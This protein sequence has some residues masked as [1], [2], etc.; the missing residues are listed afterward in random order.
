MRFAVRLE[1][2]HDVARDPVQRRGSEF[3]FLQSRPVLL[4]R[5]QCCTAFLV[6]AGKCVCCAV[7]EQAPAVECGDP[8]AA[9]RLACGLARIGCVERVHDKICANSSASSAC[10][11]TALLR[12]LRGDPSLLREILANKLTTLVSRSELVNAATTD[13]KKH[14]GDQFTENLLHRRATLC[15]HHT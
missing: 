7:G 12:S 4:G 8:W 2:P 9:D 14:L 3:G 10:T 6:H 1:L 11:S 5:T 15:P 13:V